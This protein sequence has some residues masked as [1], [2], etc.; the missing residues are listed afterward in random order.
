MFP[1]TMPRGFKG[2]GFQVCVMILRRT[3][4]TEAGVLL[5]LLLLRVSSQLYLLDFDILHVAIRD[6]SADRK[7]RQVA[8][9]TAEIPVAWEIP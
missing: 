3:H 2:V 5:L 1:G 8:D 9:T 7:P 6:S 4:F